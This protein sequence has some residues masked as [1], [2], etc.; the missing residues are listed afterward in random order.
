MYD[1]DFKILVGP[2]KGSY[3]NYVM[4][5]SCERVGGGEAKCY[6]PLCRGKGGSRSALRLLANNVVQ[7]KIS[8]RTQQNLQ[9]NYI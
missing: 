9:F 5:L 7:H 8:K 2:T 4:H 3:I 1:V 6:R